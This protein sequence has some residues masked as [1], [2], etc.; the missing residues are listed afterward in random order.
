M[1]INEQNQVNIM[2]IKD[3]EAMI[4]DVHEVVTLKY[5]D[6]LNG[7]VDVIQ[8]ILIHNDIKHRQIM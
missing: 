2:S 7:F 8:Y 1:K 6:I 3:D 5:Y 4:D